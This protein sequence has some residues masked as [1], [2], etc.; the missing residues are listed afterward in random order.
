MRKCGKIIEL[1]TSAIGWHSTSRE[2][3]KGKFEFPSQHLTTTVAKWV[4]ERFKGIHWVKLS[5]SR[6]GRKEVRRKGKERERAWSPY[7]IKSICLTGSFSAGIGGKLHTWLTDTS[8]SS[9]SKYLFR[10]LNVLEEN[11][12]TMTPGQ[13]LLHV[14]VAAARSGAETTSRG[15]SDC[16]FA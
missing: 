1:A 9:T 2:R 12:Q 15:D 5:W 14:N 7:L 4:K 10:R 16:A 3:P 6:L 11:Q 13:E 8:G